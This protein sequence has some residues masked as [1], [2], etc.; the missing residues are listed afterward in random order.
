MNIPEDVIDKK[1]YLRYISLS[2]N[3]IVNDKK[4]F[5]AS[6]GSVINLAWFPGLLTK[7]IEHLSIEEQE[8]I[9]ELKQEYFNVNNNMTVQKR[10][11]YGMRQGAGSKSLLETKRTEIIELFGRMFT[12]KEVLK[13]INDDWGLEFGD[14]N[15]IAK[16]RKEHAEEI[17]QAIERYKASYSDIRL[18]VKRSRLEE[19]VYLYG[20]QKEKFVKNKS[21]N[22]YRLLLQTLEQIRKESEG[23]RLTI[24]GKVDVNY[25][26][27]IQMHLRNE[28]FG[29]LNIKEIIL[30]RVAARMGVNPIKLIHSLNTSYYKKYSNVLGDIDPEEQSD[31]MVFP[32][33]HG[34]D[35]ERIGR[36]Q[37]M[38]D[39]HAE[40]A[41]IV[42]EK[43]NADKSTKTAEDIKAK[44][45]E[46]LKKKQTKLSK[47]N[48]KI[49][50]IT[51]NKNEE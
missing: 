21:D 13:M 47:G 50:A 38:L 19:M 10:K 37:A 4:F 33:Q 43:E 27:N 31:D 14:Y 3:P 42:D 45:L 6:D 25:E 1:A 23:E 26:M 12:A 34:Y 51:K 5:E 44:L 7:K 29:S 17:E 30:G 8:E 46:K 41:V 24:D 48:A 16:F 35:F 32:S 2:K 9:Q 15:A 11:A 49:N 22:S 40:D 18:A 20:H 36:A 39:K 28:I